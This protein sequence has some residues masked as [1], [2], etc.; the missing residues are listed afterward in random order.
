MRQNN[1]RRMSIRPSKK[2]KYNNKYNKEMVSWN[3]K[4]EMRLN[5]QHMIDC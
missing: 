1:A 5:L 4:T 3:R 2:V